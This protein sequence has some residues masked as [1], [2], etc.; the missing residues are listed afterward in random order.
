VRYGKNQDK[1]DLFINVAT[2]L[3]ASG[4]MG[5]PSHTVSRSAEQPLHPSR[6]QKRPEWQD[7]RIIPV[8]GTTE[9]RTQEP[10]GNLG[11]TRGTREPMLFSLGNKLET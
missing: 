3:P 4:R 8:K 10:S 11:K 7:R 9:P 2:V 1:R 5:H 6:V